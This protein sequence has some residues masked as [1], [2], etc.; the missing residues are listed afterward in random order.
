MSGNAFV[1]SNAFQPFAV[2]GSS[3]CIIIQL[4]FIIYHTIIQYKHGISFPEI[5]NRSKKIRIKAVIV[6]LY[7]FLFCSLIFN[8]FYL[9]H[10]SE[11]F[12]PDGYV[13]MNCN[14][15]YGILT[16][17]YVLNKTILYYS[18]F[19]RLDITY[20]DSTFEVNKRLLLTLS[21]LTVV[22]FFIWVMYWFYGP[23]DTFYYNQTY[24][25]CY[26]ETATTSNIFG[27]IGIILVIFYELFVSILSL[28]LFIKPLCYLHHI[29]ADPILHETIIKVGLLN[30]IIIIS[31]VAMYLV[32]SFTLGAIFLVI[33]NVIN[34]ICLV[35]MIN[36]HK[37]LYR[38]MC[39]LCL[40]WTC[41]QYIEDNINV[42]NLNVEI[43]EHAIVPVSATNSPNIHNS[44]PTASPISDSNSNAQFNVNNNNKLR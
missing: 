32:Y 1:E 31:T 41:C 14:I 13:K 43:T 6:I 42:K 4:L 27:T 44:P 8:L 23:K 12:V 35:L 36:I 19:L 37:Q 2:I 3:I 7:L 20:N 38:T 29:K 28:I 9:L 5:I 34:S 24:N 33:D 40:R 25:Y 26:R 30:I 10:M 16:V 39:Y 21:I 22:Y 11:V 17:L 18:Y 15:V